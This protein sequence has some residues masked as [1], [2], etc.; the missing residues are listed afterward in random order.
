MCQFTE[1][2]VH[3]SETRFGQQ[4]MNQKFK[5]NQHTATST[6]VCIYGPA[7]ASHPPPPMGMGGQYRLVL[8][9]PPR[10]LWWWYGSSGPAPPV[11]C[12]G[13]MVLLVPPPVA[14][15]GGMLVCW[16]VGMYVCM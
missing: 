7:L 5:L 3:E 12:G 4:L 6:F 8:L 10:G 11:A 16:Y 13:G 14:C 9:V 15:G 1:N 2:Y